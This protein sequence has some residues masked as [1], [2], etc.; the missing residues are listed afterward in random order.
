MLLC[1]GYDEP[2]IDCVIPLRPTTIRSL[3]SQQI[4][5][6]TRTNSGKENLLI[7]DFLWLSREHNIVKPVALIAKDQAWQ[8]E[9]E[10]QLEQ[11][12]GDLL[13]TEALASAEREAALTRRLDERR[14]EKGCEIDL[15]ESAA[16]W[17][18]PD[19]VDYAPTFAWEGK[20]IT[21]KQTIALRR[22][23]VELALVRDRGHASVI[24]SGL[25]AWLEREPASQRPKAYCHFLGH[26][27]PW[28]LTKR[29]ASRWISQHKQLTKQLTRTV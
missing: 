18:A 6:G 16:R 14:T 2:S 22:N 3:Y 1:E 21:E 13:A 19:I 24:L 25:F 15:L 12:D 27:Q 9:I 11:A 17:H 26:S 20:S 29:E 8:G 10:A 4:G 23:G 28:Q 5:R 7:L